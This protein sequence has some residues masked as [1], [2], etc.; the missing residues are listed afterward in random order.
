MSKIFDFIDFISSLFEWAVNFVKQMFGIISNA[1]SIVKDFLAPISE[2]VPVLAV[3]FGLFLSVS[4]A[5]F[6]WRLIP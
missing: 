4:V 6:I 1:V 2:Y 3:F 5:L